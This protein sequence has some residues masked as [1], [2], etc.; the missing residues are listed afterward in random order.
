VLVCKAM[1]ARTHH[2]IDQAR[3]AIQRLGEVAEASSVAAPCRTT[4][5]AID[6]GEVFLASALD[7]VLVSRIP[8]CG[9]PISLH[10]RV[11]PSRDGDILF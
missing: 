3:A 9:A 8:A 4:A 1:E 5:L 10:Y 2:L 6:T 11:V 7:Q